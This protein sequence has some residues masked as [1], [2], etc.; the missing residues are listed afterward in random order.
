MLMRY[1]D[2]V[3]PYVAPLLTLHCTLSKIRTMM[4]V[5]KVQHQCKS[6]L[7]QICSKLVIFLSCLVV[8]VSRGILR[9]TRRRSRQRPRAP[10][11]RGT[12]L[13]NQERVEGPG[14]FRC[15]KNNAFSAV[16]LHWF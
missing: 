11:D 15:N 16:G 2:S 9:R 14:G 1:N 8:G 4:W 10:R 7:W 13:V 12:Q 6:S 3:Q 5:S